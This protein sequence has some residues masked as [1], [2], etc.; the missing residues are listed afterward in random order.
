MTLAE[1][2]QSMMD[3]LKAIK[4]LN[5]SLKIDI[6]SEV[7]IDGA[8]KIANLVSM[9]DNLRIPDIVVAFEEVSSVN[10]FSNEQSGLA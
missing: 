10:D 9:I 5:R 1:Q 2:M 8:R 3:E 6:D 7:T 4:H